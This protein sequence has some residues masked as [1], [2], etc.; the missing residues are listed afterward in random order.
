LDATRAY[1]TFGRLIVAYEGHES[2]VQ[3]HVAIVNG[4]LRVGF[5]ATQDI[6]KGDRVIY[7]VSDKVFNCHCTSKMF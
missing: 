3:T 4:Q 2:N 5:L 1:G 6:H 7:K